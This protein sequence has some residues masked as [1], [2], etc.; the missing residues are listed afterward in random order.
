MVELV[1][2]EKKITEE[3]YAEFEK[4][5]STE[6]PQSLKGH[7]LRVNGG[8]LGEKDVEDDLWGLP[9]GGFNPIKYGNVTIEK[10]I[11]DIST[12]R[13]IDTGE[14]YKEGQ[15]VP[16]AYD[17]GGH[18]IFI[19]LKGSDYGCIYLYDCDGDGFFEISEGF[20]KFINK[21]YKY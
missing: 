5:F 14:E 21:L 2:C 13:N 17:N 8:F 12:I 3:D 15:Y 6:L 19:S 7:Y 16:F 18:T 10:I 20:E 1:N 4:N 11:S 9:V